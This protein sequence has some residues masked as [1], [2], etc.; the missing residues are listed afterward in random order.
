[1]KCANML[2]RVAGALLEIA[3]KFGLDNNKFLN[4]NLTRKEI[5]EISGTTTESVIRILNQL[6]RE[7]NIDLIEGKIKILDSK[8]LQRNHMRQYPN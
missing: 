8:K 1:L 2:S 3:G 6:K 4:V 5:A 7:K